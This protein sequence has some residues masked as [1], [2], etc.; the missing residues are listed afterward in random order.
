VILVDTSVWVS[1]M[2]AGNDRLARLLEQEEVACHPFVIGELACGDLKSRDAILSL[3]DA[4][5][6][7]VVADPEE[8]LA[9]VG[10]HRLWGKGLG[11]VDAHLLAA[12][13]LGGVPLWTAD[14]R[15]AEAAASLGCGYPPAP[16][17]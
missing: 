14:R 2:S 3:L 9:F 13:L 11:Y 12:A 4:L 1:H 15:L 5:P 8:V 6:Q 7:T 16:V 17:T 10:A